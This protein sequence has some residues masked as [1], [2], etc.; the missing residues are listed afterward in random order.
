[1]SLLLVRAALVLASAGLVASDSGAPPRADEILNRARAAVN[2]PLAEGKALRTRVYFEISRG[3]NPLQ[4]FWGEVS[5]AGD[6]TRMV[7]TPSFDPHGP[8]GAA[9]PGTEIRLSI[10]DRQVT[11][12][13]NCAAESAAASEPRKFE[14]SGTEDAP[15]CLLMPPRSWLGLDFEVKASGVDPKALFPSPFGARPEATAPETYWV[16]T[17]ATQS[18]LAP[19]HVGQVQ[20]WVSQ[21]EGWLEQLVLT[22]QRRERGRKDEV[23]RAT[24]CFEDL[25]VE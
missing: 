8:G 3:S 14:L 20:I 10:R 1:M 15:F 19:G 4:R 18:A 2:G 11:W 17:S 9:V 12:V 5:Q 6:E 22:L 24:I 23:I 16:L 21:S 7:L 13:A 25:R